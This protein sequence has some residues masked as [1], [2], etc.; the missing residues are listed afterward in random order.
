MAWA[1]TAEVERFDE[2]VDWFLKRTV[3]PASAAR[4]LDARLRA[5]AFWVGGGLHLA[6]IQRVF[7]KIATAIEK[8]EPF[9]VFKKAVKDELANPAHVET[10]FRNAT[11]RAYNAGR[12][13]Q[14]RD[15]ELAKLRP[16]WMFDAVLD[17][18]VT[19]LCKS[20]DTSVVAAN[21]G[22][23]DSHW[24]PLHHRCRSSVRTLRKAEAERRGISERGPAVDPPEGWGQTPKTAVPW[25]PD[26][27]KHDRELVVEINRKAAVAAP[28]RKPRKPVEHKA[29]HWE[30]HYREKYGSAAPAVAHGRAALERGLDMSVEQVRRELAKVDVPGL[31]LL[32]SSLDGLDATTTLRSAAGEIDPLRKAAATVAGHL[33]SLAPRGRVVHRGLAREPVGKRAL[34]FFSKAS[35]P[36]VSHPEDWSFRKIH[37]RASAHGPTKKIKYRTTDGVLEHEW[38]H[39]LEHVNPLLFERAAAFLESRTRAY[40]LRRLRDIS[41]GKGYRANELAKEDEF[42]SPYI[43]KIYS[44]NGRLFATEVTSMGLEVLVAGRTHWGTLKELASRD[45]EHLFFVLGQLAGP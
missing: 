9:D 28:V 17:S 30:P 24:P 31:Q 27:A 5:E 38:G 43:G 33:E 1:V 39:A 40:P 6:Q 22:W 45:P 35:G 2:A 11:Q 21:D 7:D 41:P 14:M 13:E 25:R 10:V 20:L 42:I 37:G 16:F 32:A 36:K 19:P 34:D 3:L 18:R 8:G 4:A 44:I 12:F 15:P 29:R 23:W 26:P